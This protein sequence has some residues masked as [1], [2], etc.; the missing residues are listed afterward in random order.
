ME[1]GKELEME[2]A[3]FKLIV[4]QIGNPFIASLLVG[5][6]MVALQMAKNIKAM[7]K[8][9]EGLNEKIAVILERQEH[10]DDKIKGLDFRIARL[11]DARNR[12]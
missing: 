1:A 2:A 6:M 8:S 10:H 9:M 5:L 12:A 11:E 3:L 4:D 7:S